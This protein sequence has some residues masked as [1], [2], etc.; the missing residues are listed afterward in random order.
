MTVE[1]LNNGHKLIR[2]IE[3]LEKELKMWKSMRPDTAK[4]SWLVVREQND[5][6]AE[7]DLHIELG[8]VKEANVEVL[9]LKINEL[10]K[11]FSEI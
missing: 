3:D 8:V 9:K 11:Q 6:E 2:A 4:S 5:T 7:F 1:Q 10:R